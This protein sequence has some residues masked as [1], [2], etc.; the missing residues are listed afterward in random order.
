MDAILAVRRSKNTSAVKGGGDCGWWLD[1][2]R[3]RR[4]LNVVQSFLGSFDWRIDDVNEEIAR[5][6][7]KQQK[8]SQSDK[9]LKRADSKFHQFHSS[10]PTCRR[11]VE[12]MLTDDDD[13]LAS[14]A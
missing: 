8:N 6:A 9:R 11:Q 2:W 1:E 14:F 5:L 7:I 3:P 13:S 10:Q 4:P 12:L